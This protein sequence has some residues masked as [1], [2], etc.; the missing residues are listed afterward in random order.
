MTKYTVIIPAY[1]AEKTLGRCLD[2]LLSQGRSDI[3]ILLINDGS[4]DPGL[5]IT[6]RKT[7]ASPRPGIWA[8]TWPAV[9]T[10]ALWT[11]TTM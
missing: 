5:N 11:A 10:S 4:T 6:A 3:R 7:A 9:N 8:W 2:S 1:H